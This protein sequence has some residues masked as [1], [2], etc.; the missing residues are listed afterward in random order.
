[1]ALTAEHLRTMLLRCQ[2][3]WPDVRC[4]FGQIAFWSPHIGRDDEDV[5]IDESAWGYRL[6]GELEYDGD[7]AAI[8]AI[9]EWARPERVL[10]T[11]DDADVLARHGLR[12]DPSGPRMK[13]NA[14]SLDDIEEPR[15]PPG[16]RLTTM[17]DYAD[18]A[19]RSAAHRSAFAPG[20]QFTDDVYAVV[21]ATWPYRADLDCACV[22]PDG[23]VASYALAW[24]DDSNAV[25]ELEPVGTH[26]DHRRR[27]L[28]RAT[29]LFALQRLR[30]EGAKTALV[31]CR[32]ADADPAACALYASIGFRERRRLVTFTSR[33]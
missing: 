22:A 17:A 25:G 21:R 16:Y 11:L 8:D 33:S 19:S 6:G 2:G 14:R 3:H 29:N 23:S 1:M 18:T 12:H 13:E 7:P 15:A 4:T 27:G 30:D 24:L 28:A 31:A 26:A 10:T 32:E 20:S 9:L 5:R